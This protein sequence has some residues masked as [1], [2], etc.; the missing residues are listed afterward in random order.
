MEW[1]YVQRVIPDSKDYFEPVE[2]ALSTLFLPALLGDDSPEEALKLREL[3]CFPVRL[4]RLGIPNPI[5]QAEQCFQNSVT[6]TAAVSTSLKEGR[7]LDAIGYLK[8]QTRD[9]CF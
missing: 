4:A 8:F 6:A 2:E 5:A 3:T 7:T 1:S 9:C